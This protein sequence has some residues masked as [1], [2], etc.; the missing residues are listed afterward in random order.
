MP[1]TK[2]VERLARDKIHQV[3][4][5]LRVVVNLSRSGILRTP[6]PTVQAAK[7]WSSNSRLVASPQRKST[8]RPLRAALPRA[9]ASM[10]RLKSTPVTEPSGPTASSMAKAKSPVPQQT[11]SVRSPGATA[12]AATPR[13]RQRW[14]MPAVMMLFIRS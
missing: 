4:D 9:T 12:A 14:C 11:S 1:D 13:R 8:S 7:L 2:D 3:I 6:K 10:R 5:A